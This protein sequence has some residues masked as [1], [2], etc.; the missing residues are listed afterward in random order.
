MLHCSSCRV[1]LCINLYIDVINFILNFF[2]EIVIFENVMF[3]ISA[4]LLL[5]CYDYIDN[6]DCR[7]DLVITP[8]LNQVLMQEILCIIVL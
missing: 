5:C 6:V 3:A 4:T 8:V 7:Q 1:L 2:A